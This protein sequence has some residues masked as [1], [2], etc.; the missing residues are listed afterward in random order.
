MYDDLTTLLD[1]CSVPPHEV[2]FYSGSVNWS[3]FDL[4][5]RTHHFRSLTSIVKIKF[6]I[7]SCGHNLYIEHSSV[8]KFQ[9]IHLLIRI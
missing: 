3:W 4:E 5:T 1:C 8:L 7:K 6:M 9:E 2:L